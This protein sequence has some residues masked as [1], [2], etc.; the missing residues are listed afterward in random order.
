MPR[1]Y[2]ENYCLPLQLS[3]SRLLPPTPLPFLSYTLASCFTS[4]S[5][6]S[7]C[8]KRSLRRACDSESNKLWQDIFQ[9]KCSAVWQWLPEGHLWCRHPLSGTAINFY[10]ILASKRWLSLHTNSYSHRFIDSGYLSKS[11]N[12]FKTFS[13]FSFVLV[14]LDLRKELKVGPVNKWS[15]ERFIFSGR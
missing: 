3:C 7:M 14:A 11:F 15:L 12:T 10:T 9:V 5:I 2:R 4:Q 8:S 13:L 1:K 6:K